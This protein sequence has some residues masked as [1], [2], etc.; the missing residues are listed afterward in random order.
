MSTDQKQEQQ[1]LST[2]QPS[3]MAMGVF[4]SVQMY[5]DYHKIAVQLANSTLVPKEFQGSP[6]N[7]MIA[8]NMSSRMKA[9]P[10]QIMQSIYMVHGKPSFSASF[11]G[12]IIEQSGKFGFLEYR[13]QGEPGTD[14]YGCRIV[15]TLSSTGQTIEGPLVDVRMAKAEGWWGKNGSKWPT[16]TETMLGNRAV[17]FFGRRYA[18]AILLGMPS[19]DELE[20]IKD[21][22]P[23]QGQQ[24]LSRKDLKDAL[25]GEHDIVDVPHETADEPAEEA[26]VSE[27]KTKAKP[28][29][30]DEPKKQQSAG[31][32]K[33]PADQKESGK[34]DPEKKPESES[35]GQEQTGSKDDGAASGNP[36]WTANELVEKIHNAGSIEE[37][38]EALSLTSGF[39]QA[40]QSKVIRAASARN[41][42]LVASRGDK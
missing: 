8:L 20:D 32:D 19:Q 39:S 26:P 36:Q 22:N 37:V 23:V 25:T 1:Q 3:D 9:D 7:V 6:A 29:K 41:K 21:V 35:T 2:V 38:N 28:V 16:M 15:T 13:M 40:D 4:S 14:D 27:S 24:P 5:G 11:I 12:A 18:G 30:K 31:P 17:T 10:L 42:D 34:G 33:G